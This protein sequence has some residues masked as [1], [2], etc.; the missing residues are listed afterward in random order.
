MKRLILFLALVVLVFVFT[1]SVGAVTG[2]KSDEFGEVT[3]VSGVNEDTQI[4]DKTS[5][6][7]L[8][9]SDGTYTTYPAYYISDTNLQFQGTV[10]YEFDALNKA[11][12]TNYDMDSIIRLE[13]LA[14]S[15]CMNQN[16]G[17]L[18]DRKNLKEIA[19]PKNT[20]MKEICGQQFKSSGIEKAQIPASVEILGSHIFEAC[21][22]LKEVN[23]DEGFSLT[24]L[25]A[26][27]FTGCSSLEKITLPN[28]VESI[29]R[30]CFA[31]ATSLKE[32][33]FGE[34]FKSMGDQVFALCQNNMVIYAPATFMAEATSI[35]TGSFT[36]DSGNLHLVTLFFSGTKEQAQALI[37]K[38]SHRGLK[39]AKLVEWDGGEDSSYIPVNPTSWTIVYSYNICSHKWSDKVETEVVDF[40]SEI[41][42]GLVCTK[43]QEMDVSERIS[44]IFECMGDSITENPDKNGKYYMTVG[45]KIDSEAYE[46]YNR[47]APLD[48]G[49]VVCFANTVGNTPMTIA[50][51]KAVPTNKNQVFTVTKSELSLSF[52]DVKMSGLTSKANGKELIMCIYVFDGENI[53]YLC[54]NGQGT[55]ATGTVISVK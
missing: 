12:G 32:I 55:K 36:Y 37:N 50:N 13:I 38:A 47:Y 26:Q 6:V 20:K 17:K 25:P 2:V 23:F 22:S 40:Y 52:G 18:Q 53:F 10:Q 27:M 29:G 31:G 34:K 30:S 46:K 28:S 49:F 9:N 43:C 54:E 48:Y 3:H 14:D 5:R 15:T 8:K 1:V 11:L 24:S 45:Y 35:T 42:V 33:H 19:F 7:V 51:G 16:G 21:A 39:E 4:Q 41:K 44:P